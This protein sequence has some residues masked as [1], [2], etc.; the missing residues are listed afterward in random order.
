MHQIAWRRGR[1]QRD[2]AVE[3]IPDAI[4]PVHASAITQASLYR[5]PGAEMRYLLSDAC[6]PQHLLARRL[7][8]F[9]CEV[10]IK[11]NPVF[12]PLNSLAL[13]RRGEE[14]SKDNALLLPEPAGDEEEYYPVLRGGV[15]LRP[16]A[17]PVG[18][19]W[20][21]RGAVKKN[22]ERYRQPKLLVVKCTGVLQAA[23]DLDGHV[24]LQTLYML[25]LR[26][27][28]PHLEEDDL[29]FLLA[30][31]N[32][33][34]LRTYIYMVQT[35]Y[36]WVQPQIE[37]HVLGHLPVPTVATPEKKQ[38]VARARKLLSACGDLSSVVKLE[39]E[40]K[41]GR[42]KAGLE[43][44]AIYEEQERAICALYQTA[45]TEGRE[46]RLI[47]EFPDKGVSYG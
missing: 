43:W 29:Y 31:L 47:P 32:S 40:S 39:V 4:I 15:D 36:K 10:P 45:L 44:Q 20:I 34:L 19:R 33:R 14:L 25:L 8:E 30:L 27:E 18:H 26:T 11:E 38:I 42:S 22:L 5:Q 17:K 28:K 2:A 35:A 7:H 41:E 13:I 9:L 37:Q 21:K 3:V 1:W 6:S 24:V 16:Y 12:V 46:A 23:L